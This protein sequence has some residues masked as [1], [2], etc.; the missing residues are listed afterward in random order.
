[1]QRR[2]P[3][4]A[5]RKQDPVGRGGEDAGEHRFQPGEAPIRP[6]PVPRDRPQGPHESLRRLNKTPQHTVGSVMFARSCQVAC[7]APCVVLRV[8]LFLVD[9]FFMSALVCIKDC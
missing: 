2:A 1:M 7:S 8:Q 3:L 9:S 5:G 6:P 4:H